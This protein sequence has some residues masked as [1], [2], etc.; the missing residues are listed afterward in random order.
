MLAAAGNATFYHAG[1][2]K[3][4]TKLTTNGKRLLK[5]ARRLKL[6]GQATFTPTGKHA[7]VATK[8]FTLTR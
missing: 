6:T 2:L 1:M 3:I 7:V 5:H 8:K 4:T